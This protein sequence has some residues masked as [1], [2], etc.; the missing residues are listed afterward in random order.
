MSRRIDAF[1]GRGTPQEILELKR[2]LTE[3]RKEAALE[4]DK[5]IHQGFHRY[6]DSLD[7]S[8][9]HEI[10]KILCSAKRSRLQKKTNT[11]GTSSE[12]I[13]KYGE[14]FRNQFSRPSDAIDWERVEISHE[15]GRETTWIHASEIRDILSWSPS[16]KAGGRSG[17]RIELLKHCRESISQPLAIYFNK[18]IN[19]GY[20]P[21]QWKK[22]MI[23]PIP[24]KPGSREISDYRPISLTEVMRKLFERCILD[25]LI[26]KIEPLDVAQ[27]GFR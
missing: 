5:I 10:M 24:K 7:L 20:I 18:L 8:E 19:F 23:I 4:A 26:D 3:A 2:Q 27:G 11:L 14:F 9:S 1:R 13:N 12:K 22:A 6:V 17:I 15:S 16:G 21:S 25:E